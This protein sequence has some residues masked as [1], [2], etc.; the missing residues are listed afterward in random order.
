MSSLSKKS[1]IEYHLNFL[2]CQ[3]NVIRRLLKNQTVFD[4]LYR[5]ATDQIGHFDRTYQREESDRVT[6][7]DQVCVADLPIEI[8][9]TSSPKPIS[10]PIESSSSIP[11]APPMP[12]SL[13]LAIQLQKQ[14]KNKSSPPV[15]QQSLWANVRFIRF[16]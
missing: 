11:P 1:D 7:I 15:D 2:D 16:R 10:I 5:A 14:Q 6:D 9:Q 13:D 4:H 8:I 3:P 12:P